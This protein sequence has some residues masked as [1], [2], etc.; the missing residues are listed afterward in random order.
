MVYVPFDVAQTVPDNLQYHIKKAVDVLEKNRTSHIELAEAIYPVYTV[1]GYQ[2]FVGACRAANLTPPTKGWVS[3]LA[4]VWKFWALDCVYSKE[5][6]SRASI[7]RLYAVGKAYSKGKISSLEEGYQMAV[8]ADEK[9]FNEYVGRE[10]SE[11]KDWVAIK[12]PEAVHVALLE[13]AEYLSQSVR[14]PLTI[15]SFLEVVA[16]V[17]K[18]IP[19]ETWANIWKELHGEA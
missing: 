1:G 12:V 18:G 6:L 7:N 11:G 15:V 17:A 13:A 16:E 19:Q 9:T 8:E 2:A 3:R 5:R 4:Y 10:W 14:H